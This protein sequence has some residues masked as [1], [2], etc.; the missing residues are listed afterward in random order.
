MF[1]TSKGIERHAGEI[2]MRDV[3]PDLP[4]DAF[5]LA[6]FWVNSERSFVAVGFEQDWSPELLGSLLIE[7]LYT[8]ADAYA[9]AT[10]IPQDDALQM[11]WK[12]V[13]E[14]RARL[15]SGETH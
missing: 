13:D 14:E 12:G 4:A 1:G 10:D 8:A 11:L 9:S 6:R 3:H 15:A 2:Q 7:C 5:E